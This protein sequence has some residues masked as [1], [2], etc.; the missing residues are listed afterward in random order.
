MPAFLRD[1]S[2]KEVKNRFCL[3][4]DRKFVTWSLTLSVLLSPHLKQS[5]Q[6]SDN[7]TL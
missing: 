7:S 1:N 6:P 5:T 3:P 2:S 4:G